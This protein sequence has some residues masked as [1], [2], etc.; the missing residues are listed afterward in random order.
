MAA[1]QS[2]ERLLIDRSEALA[3]NHPDSARM[4]LDNIVVPE[5]EYVLCLLII[6]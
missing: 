5:N 4:L 2:K 1:Q 6:R 3:V